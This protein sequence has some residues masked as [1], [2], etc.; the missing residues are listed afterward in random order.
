MENRKIN[1]QIIQPVVPKYRLPLFKALISNGKFNICIMAGVKEPGGVKSIDEK[2]ININL[3]HNIYVVLK[4]LFWQRDLYLLSNMRQGDVLIINGNIKMLS[5][6]PLIFEAKK[7]KVAI[8]WWGHG[9]SSTTSNLSFFLRKHIIKLFSDIVLLYTE[10]EKELFVNNSFD[11]NKVFYMNNTVYTEDI[12]CIKKHI[13][14]QDIVDIKVEHEIK[15]QKILLF[16]GRLRDSPPTN[17]LIALKSLK[18]LTSKCVLVVVGDGVGRDALIKTSKE[19][20]VED[21][22]LFLGSIYD[23]RKLA[24]WFMAAD[25]FVYPGAIGLSL[26]HAFSYALPVVTH[27]KLTQHGPEIAA[28][29]NEV[30]G[31]TFNMNDEVDLAKSIEVILKSKDYY[32]KNALK[33]IEN[34][35]SYADMLLR[36]EECI[37]SAS[38]II[39]KK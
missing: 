19:L 28:L 4:K 38:T 39:Q 21:K 15:N 7:R 22:V 13:T 8:V 37:I 27:N 17:L 29:K 26:L 6:Y 16:V 9:W 32:S 12:N 14:Q 3:N 11:S 2:I 30:N 5:N 35:Y 1:V 31:L 18:Y 24:P 23:E 20:G 33:T 36:V 34:E 25:C 10:K